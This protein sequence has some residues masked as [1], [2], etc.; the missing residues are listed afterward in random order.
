MIG[1]V[2]ILILANVLLDLANGATLVALPH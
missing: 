2:A 1:V